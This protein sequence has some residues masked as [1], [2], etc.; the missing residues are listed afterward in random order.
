MYYRVEA[1]KVGRRH[2]AE[3][4]VDGLGCEGHAYRIGVQASFAIKR[5][6][7]PVHLVSVAVQ[8]RSEPGA[9][10]SLGAGDKDFHRVR[11]SKGVAKS[12]GRSD[13]RERFDLR[14]TRRVGDKV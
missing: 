13:R 3:I 7:K 5:R 11:L 2:I 1:L 10:V 9:D 8:P 4:F 12:D 6:I 14:L